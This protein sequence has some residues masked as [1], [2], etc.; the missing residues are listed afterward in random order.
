MAGGAISEAANSEAANSEAANSEAANSEAAN[1]AAPS[2]QPEH[3]RVARDC[4]FRSRHF[5]FSLRLRFARGVAVAG[6]EGEGGD[7]AGDDDVGGCGGAELGLDRAVVDA[8][9]QDF[10]V[11]LELDNQFF[12]GR[13]LGA[14]HHP[15]RKREPLDA[16]RL[17]FPPIEKGRAE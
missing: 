9:V 2:A 16:K 4:V 10:A 3:L 6:G 11:G 8:R 5:Q 7:V 17:A 14:E 13:A 12:S 1:S 15:Q